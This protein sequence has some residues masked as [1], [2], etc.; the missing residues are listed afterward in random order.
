LLTGPW[1]G[2]WD[3]GMNLGRDGPGKKSILMGWAWMGLHEKPWAWMDLE[4]LPRGQHC[5]TLPGTKLTP[6]NR[7]SG[8]GQNTQQ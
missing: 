3:W 6:V 1:G 2:P 8:S 4:T 5:S 7:M